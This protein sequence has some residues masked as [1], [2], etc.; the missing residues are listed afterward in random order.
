M[1]DLWDRNQGRSL[2]ARPGPQA[3]YR[4]R[5]ST[6]LEGGGR[7]CTRALLR[8][9]QTRTWGLGRGPTE[10]PPVI[11]RTVVATPVMATPA[12]A[13]GFIDVDE[14]TFLSITMSLRARSEGKGVMVE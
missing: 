12:I 11:A 13:H 2:T 8:G 7:G 3:N 4:P 9:A 14:T 5:V 1:L 6:H 10:A